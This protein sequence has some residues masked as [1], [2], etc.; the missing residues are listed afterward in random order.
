MSTALI[1]S[2]L[3]FCAALVHGLVLEGWRQAIGPESGG[4][5]GREIPGPPL[6]ISV[7]VPARNAAATIVPLLQDLY[8]QR[9]PRE[10]YE[11]LV[12]D[13]HSSDGTA[14]AVHGMAR[15][16]PVLRLVP[17]DAGQGKK[18][19]ISLGVAQAQG[20]VVVLTDA[21]ARCGPFR[22]AAIARLW[23]REA[24]DLLLMPVHT[25]GGKGLVAW[26]QRKEQAALQAA[27][28][29]SASGGRPVLS[30]GANMAFARNAFLR[31]GGFIGDRH[32]SGDDMFLLQR[33]RRHRMAISCLADPAVV[34]RV[35]PEA[36][37]RGFV[38]QRLRWAGKMWAYREWAGLLAAG[39]AVL[40]PWVLLALTI[41]LLGSVQLGQGLFYVG[42]LLAAAWAVWLVPIIRLVAAMERSHA[43]VMD[44]AGPLRADGSWSTLPALLLFTLYAPA[45]AIV[46][47]FVRP[48]W[49]GR[50]I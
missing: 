35:L 15:T 36:D 34:V 49:K 39:A 4:D 14:A 32:A 37:W 8:A 21:D 6:R 11:V 48:S 19:A 24:P 9:Y 43:Q 3:A 29:G 27:S 2:L 45:I 13:D 12:I 10:A 38:A 23:H 47:I 46:S 7:L 18:A 33:M 50:R 20:D 16:W 42:V 26:L 44:P 30:N 5:R 22:L 31:V 17:A 28:V 41:L 1:L 40:F 25:T